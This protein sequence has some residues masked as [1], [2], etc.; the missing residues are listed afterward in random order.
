MSPLDSA[1]VERGLR[2]LFSTHPMMKDAADCINDLRKDMEYWRAVAAYLASC[3]A[4]TAESDG[5]LKSVS[6]SRKKRYAAICQTASQAMAGHWYSKY[7]ETTVDDA[8]D[9]CRKAVEML[10]FK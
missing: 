10:G 8:G 3:H 9:R 4:A 5:M 7:R 6:E 2:D 1:V